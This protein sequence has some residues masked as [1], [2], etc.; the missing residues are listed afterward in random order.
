MPSFDVKGMSCNH[1]VKSV[2]AAVQAIDPAARIDVDLAQGVVKVESGQ[3][4]A[5]IAQAIG[6][7]GY[8]ATPRA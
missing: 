2:T 6:E 3:P 1:C 7:A 4:A 8:E 5:A